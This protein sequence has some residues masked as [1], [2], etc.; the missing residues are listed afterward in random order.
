MVEYSSSSSSDEGSPAFLKKIHKNEATFKYPINLEGNFPS[1]LYISI[2]KTKTLFSI[3]AEIAKKIEFPIPIEDLHLSLSGNFG[4]H[5]HQI[6]SFLKKMK[7]FQHPLFSYF[8]DLNISELGIHS[9][10]FH[11]TEY[12]EF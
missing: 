3:Q 4:L 1:F 10:I 5:L 9:E 7:S 2:P 6:D 12:Q 11:C 8:S